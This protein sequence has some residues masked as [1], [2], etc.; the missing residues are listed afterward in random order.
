[1]NN[2]EKLLIDRSLYS[3]HINNLLKIFPREQI[4][5]NY[6]DKIKSNPI[7]LLNEISVFLDL[8]NFCYESIDKKIG[9]GLSPRFKSI[10]IIRNQLY[11]KLVDLRFSKLFSSN[12]VKTVNNLYKKHL[13][14]QN[15]MDVSIYNLIINCYGWQI[16]Y[17]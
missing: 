6:F 11:Y 1:M 5:V 2:M 14:K 8:N 4:L 10:E 3:H 12:I 9:K 7:E 13:S 17:S 16:I 15:E